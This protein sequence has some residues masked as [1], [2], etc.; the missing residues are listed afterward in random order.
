MAWSRTDVA[1]KPVF[2]GPEIAEWNAILARR[3]AYQP[4]C[5]LNGLETLE[6]LKSGKFKLTK[7]QGTA[8]VVSIRWIEKP[9]GVIRLEAYAPSIGL[10][11]T[12]TIVEALGEAVAEM[13]K[14]HV[15]VYWYDAAPGQGMDG[16]VFDALAK[17]TGAIWTG[18]R[19]IK[20]AQE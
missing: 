17:A 4:A 20:A 6:S 7:F 9:G 8:G 12:A 14:G 18:E 11:D 19:W 10:D 13:L 5:K 15:A 1:S 3:K 16:V 2:T